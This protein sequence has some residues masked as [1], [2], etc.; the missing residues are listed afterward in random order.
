MGLQFSSSFTLILLFFLEQIMSGN[1]M[2]GDILISNGDYCLYTYFFSFM[3]MRPGKMVLLL[4]F[5][6]LYVHE[7]I[8][9]SNFSFKHVKKQRATGR[10]RDGATFPLS[11]TL[12][13]KYGKDLKKLDRDKDVADDQL[14]YKGMVWVFANIS[15]LVTFTADGIV[16]S[17]NHNFSLMLFGYHENELVGKVNKSQ[18]L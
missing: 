6:F 9:L 18:L 7:W 15:G 2:S 8:Y 5:R 4:T 10:T 17:C 13:P 14:F 3:L 1:D 16:H 11:I 12:K